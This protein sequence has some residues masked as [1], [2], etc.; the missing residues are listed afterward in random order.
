MD[1]A[2]ETKRLMVA[3]R[4]VSLMLICVMTLDTPRAPVMMQRIP[5]HQE[6]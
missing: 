3:V 4:P 6:P 1:P 5:T 2:A